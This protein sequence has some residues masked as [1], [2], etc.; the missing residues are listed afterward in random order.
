MKKTKL[1]VD[2][3]FDFELV[4]ITSSTKF[5][6]LCWSINNGIGLRLKKEEDFTLENVDGR[7]MTFINY[8]HM[9][10]SCEFIL[11]KN[12]SPDNDSHLILPEFPH[13][14]YVLKING[15]FQTFASEEVIKQLREVKYIEYIAPISIDKLKSK[16]NFLY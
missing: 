16:V 1:V 8:S 6:K 4:G 15:R 5:H 11:F 13:F 10:D 9:D 14:D 12:K 7:E 3:E 2:F